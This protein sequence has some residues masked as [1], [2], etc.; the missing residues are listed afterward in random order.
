MG[1]GFECSKKPLRCRICPD[2][3]RS[4][5]NVSIGCSMSSEGSYPNTV[6]TCAF[7]KTMTP[8]VSAITVASGAAFN[9]LVASP[10]ERSILSLFVGK[11]HA[12]GYA[13]KVV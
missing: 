9:R 12:V 5:S 13:S 10:P 6:C 3:K 2:R 11:R 7:A 8:W 4:G 1:L